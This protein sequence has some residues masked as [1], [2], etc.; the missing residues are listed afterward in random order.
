M[1]LTGLI[2]TFS[3][4]HSYT[5]QTHTLIISTDTTATCV[6]TRNDVSY[7]I[8]DIIYGDSTGCGSPVLG[9]FYVSFTIGDTFL[10]V[11]VL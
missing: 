2:S 11:N 7:T 4:A 1:N 5:Q 6:L 8:S 10:R 3:I 9:S